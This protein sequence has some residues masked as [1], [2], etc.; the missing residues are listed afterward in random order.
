MRLWLTI[1]LLTLLWL[2]ARAER[3]ESFGA[4]QVHYNAVSSGFL[5]PE[6]ARA[7]GIVRSRVRGVLLVSLLKDE[8]PVAARVSAE[9]RSPR[10]ELHQ[11]NMR[12]IREGEAVY[13]LGSF[14]I[15]DGESLRFSLRVTPAQAPGEFNVGFRQQFFAD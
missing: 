4:Y 11:I 3:F 7:Y 5:K 15:V 1:G 9:A 8:Q 10:G 14:P 2:P 12:Q 6:V 13:Y